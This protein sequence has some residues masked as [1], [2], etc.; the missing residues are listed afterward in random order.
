MAP[1]RY[2]LQPEQVGLRL[3][4]LVGEQPAEGQEIGAVDDLAAF[5]IRVAQREDG[6]SPVRPAAARIGR[7]MF[8]PM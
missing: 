5:M 3:G 6:V 1:Q 7:V 8:A 2:F 4:D